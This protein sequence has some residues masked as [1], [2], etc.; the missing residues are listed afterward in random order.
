M[1][2]RLEGQA[3]ARLRGPCS[4]EN[5]FRSWGVGRKEGGR[6]DR[7]PRAEAGAQSP[8]GGIPARALHGVGRGRTVGRSV[9]QFLCLSR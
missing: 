3:G 5:R 9:P 1:R 6:G 2:V 4:W 8:R 7:W